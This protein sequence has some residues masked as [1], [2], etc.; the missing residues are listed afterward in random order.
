MLSDAFKTQSEFGHFDVESGDYIITRR[1]TPRQWLNY[2]WNDEL[3]SI[4]S[5]V[6][7][8]YGFHQDVH[9]HRTLLIQGRRVYLQ[10]EQ[11][12]QTWSAEGMD[13]DSEPQN[14]CCRH[15]MG[16]TCI[17]LQQN[18]VASQ[19]EIFI[20]RGTAAELW[21][22]TLRNVSEGN[23][24]LRVVGVLDSIV[25][26][27]VGHQGY[28][29]RNSSRYDQQKKAIIYSADKSDMG[30]SPQCY[31]STSAEVSG[32]D[33]RYASFYGT[34]Y[35]DGLPAGVRHRH[36]ANSAVC[37]FEKGCFVLESRHSL[38]PGEQVEVFFAVGR[39]ETL[40]DID[41]T[42]LIIENP[43]IRAK[44]LE[45]TL[46][47]FKKSIKPLQVN[48]GAPILDH[49]VNTWLKHQLNFNATW[50]RDYFNGYRDLCQDVESLTVID[51]VK[52]HSKLITILSYQYPSGYAPRAWLDGKA[53]DHGHSDSPVWIVFAVYALVME[54]GNL[55]ILE[56]VVPYYE[57]D[58]GSIYDHC[59][60]AMDWLWNDRGHNGLC[61][62]RKG[63]WNDALVKA[64]WHGRGT[65]TWL[66]MAYYRALVQFSELAEAL[67]RGTD[68]ARM[69]DRA[70]KMRQTIDIAAW[71]GEYY[72]RGTTDNEEV[73][74]SSQNREGTM[75]A[76]AQSWAVLSGVA[77]GDKGKRA[78][79]ALDRYLED[80]IGTLTIKDIYTKMDTN[81]GPITAQ[82]PGAYQNQSVYCHSNSFKIA[83][84][85]VL[86]RYDKAWRTFEKIM[87]FSRDRK[88]DF[89]EP[90]VI[91][92]CYFG[93]R[94]GYRYDEPGQSWKTGTAG[95]LVVE[96]SRYFLGLKPTL[97]GLVLDP[98]MPSKMGNCSIMRQFRDCTY[99]VNYHKKEG[100]SSA[101][102]VSVTVDG[103]D[104]A[105]KVLP[106][107]TGKKVVVDVKLA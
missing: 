65:S 104:F 68:R 25:D 54:T 50:A 15:R 99:I 74:G 38:Q 102:I 82:R 24:R 37:E 7:Q 48:F 32:F 101:K 94:A 53:L 66:S 2:L 61:K 64:G 62:I 19:L 98:C 76:N 11:S 43:L 91:P 107:A 55:D 84:D 81:I 35:R 36:L 41:R 86:G 28:Y 30:H 40:A 17:E 75:Y 90:Y 1:D 13:G 80:D 27:E 85:C 52:S 46:E 106:I 29:T 95:W 9:S 6:G 105:D 63:D 12:S 77:L 97:K 87:P 88:I 44:A 67:D 72:L 70:E 5:N 22:L 42:Q 83:A 47:F 4:A 92:N 103:M 93:P 34:R 51:P 96:I 56:E 10:D 18:G 71:D 14:Y 59:L 57:K 89:G 100:V 45:E 33:C 69:L 49:W 79:D 3:L 58:Q 16:A 21:K 78:M 39:Y 31:F 20:P 60:R 26:G 8:G 73:F 23:K